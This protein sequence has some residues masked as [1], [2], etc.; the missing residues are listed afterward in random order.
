MKTRIQAVRCHAFAAVEKSPSGKFRPRQKPLPLRSVLSLDTLPAPQLSS[1]NDVL[2]Q[3][4]F[5]LSTCSQWQGRIKKINKSSISQQK[6]R[7]VT[8]N[9][10]AGVNNA[11]K[12]HSCRK[13]ERKTRNGCQRT[14]RSFD[15]FSLCRSNTLIC[16]SSTTSS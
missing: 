14:L 6:E 3:I 7:T 10:D 15:G 13:R 5:V 2:I 8:K 4:H 11:K 16:L 1:E 12:R 9:K